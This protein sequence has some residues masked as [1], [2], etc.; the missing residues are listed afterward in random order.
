VCGTGPETRAALLP[1][2][3]GE[4]C[5]RHNINERVR[6]DL[7]MEESPERAQ[8]LTRKEGEGSQR[9][10]EK[11]RQLARENG[12]VKLRGAYG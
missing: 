3:L 12:L 1:K 7:S 9:G 11:K 10:G 8:Y 5:L 4:P 2:D 6:G